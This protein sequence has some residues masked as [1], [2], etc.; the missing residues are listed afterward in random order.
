[1]TRQRAWVPFSC[2][3]SIAVVACSSSGG[4]TPSKGGDAA[5]PVGDG[6]AGDADAP[7]S[8]SGAT[9][10]VSLTPNGTPAG[11][12]DSW[13]G[14]GQYGF[15]VADGD[16]DP[17]TGGLVRVTCSVAA[18]GS[19][20]QLQATIAS[21]GGEGGSVQ[22]T[23]SGL[24]TGVGTQTLTVTVAESAG[25]YTDGA[26]GI[27]YSQL[28]EGVSPGFWSALLVCTGLDDA[29]RNASCGAMGQV[30]LTNCSQ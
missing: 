26:C 1:M 23:L 6:G 25:T 5:A 7:V 12:P 19:A 9:A 29:A 11:C 8:H 13:M 24:L 22:L 21:T 20:F 28:G 17:T 18:M 2:A 3:V 16:M 14:V 10:Y 27:I 4:T 30:A 15:P